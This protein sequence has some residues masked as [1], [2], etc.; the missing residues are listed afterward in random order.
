MG[1]QEAGHEFF[2][3]SVTNQLFP[4]FPD[5]LI[6]RLQQKFGFYI[7]CEVPNKPGF[8]VVRLV[9]SWATPEGAIASFL[10][11]LESS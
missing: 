11:A 2:Y 10:R 9:T 4:V 3:E 7:W 5:A 1:I 6:E 8:S